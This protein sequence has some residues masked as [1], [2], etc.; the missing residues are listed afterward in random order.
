MGSGDDRGTGGL[1]VAGACHCGRVRLILP[2]APD[3]VASCNC[4]LCR[5]LAWLV[6]YY[7]PAEV[8]AEGETVAYVWG[9]RLLAI[10][11]CPVCGCGTHWRALDE[12]LAGQLP[13]DL[14]RS[15]ERRMGINARML[16]G[17]DPAAVEIR[18]VDNAE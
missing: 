4:S 2:R 11:H 12:A 7:D 18:L 16:D 13:D 6:A 10:H 17:F 5:K 1:S 15:L 14:R 8:E 3:W 9:D